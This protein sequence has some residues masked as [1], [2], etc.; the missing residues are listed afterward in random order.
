MPDRRE[1]AA[2]RRAVRAPACGGSRRSVRP[3]EGDP[4]DGRRRRG[5]GGGDEGP[6]RARTPRWCPNTRGAQRA[7][8]AGF[9]RDRGGGLGQRHAQPAQRQPLHRRVARR[10]R[11]ADRAAAR[12]RRH[13]RGDRRDQLRLP[14]R[15]GRRPGAGGRRSSTGWSPT[16]PTGSRSATPPAWRT[17]APGP[18]AASTAV[19]DRQPGRA[20]AAALPQH[21][22]HGAGEHARPRWS[23]ASPSSTRA[24]AGS[25]A[26]RTRRAPAATWPPRRSCTCC[27]TWASTPASTSTR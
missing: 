10:H 27:T 7:L 21:P 8:A 18:R 6:R 5:V 26:A 23:W 9:T 20:A 15:G 12:R 11:R 4:A 17:P 22:G 16:A 25:A 19:R 24:S 14:V 2:A 3:P 13:C 1:G